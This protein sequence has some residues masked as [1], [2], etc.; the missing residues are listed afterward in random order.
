[1]YTEWFE[2][3]W[4]EYPK[5]PGNSKAAAFR[6]CTARIKQGSTPDDLLAGTLRYK[7]YADA[8]GTTGTAYTKMAQTF[9]GRDMHY[10]E[11]W[12][13]PI[14]SSGG[15]RLSAVERVSQANSN[16]P[17][18][19]SNAEVVGFYDANVRAQM[20]QQFRGY[21]FGRFLGKGT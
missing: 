13:L 18:E 7:A 1:M 20:D 9:Y 19:S 2:Q 10:S 17:A 4:K 16:G 12:E 5:R 14:E 3:M 6:Q 15:N 21:G 11:E 8:T